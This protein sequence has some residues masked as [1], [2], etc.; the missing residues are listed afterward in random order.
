M[1]TEFRVNSYQSNWQDESHVL[2]LRDGGFLV[3]WSS[4]FNEYD[5]TDLRT[6]YVAAQ[7]YDANAMPVGGE[8]ILRA[9][10]EGSSDAPRATQLKNG[11][12]VVTWSEATND[13]ILTNDTYIAARIFDTSGQA[14][15]DVIYVDTVKSNDAVYPEVVATGSGGFV[16]S[17][18]AE[19]G[20][21]NFDEVYYRSYDADGQALGKDKVLNTR[22]N[23]FDELVHQGRRTEQWQQRH[24]LEFG[25]RDQRRHQ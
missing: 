16:V 12:I 22:S 3:T 21:K 24:H 25:G 23:D 2:A 10:E 14:V 15:S 7:F 4:Y 11:N 20:R 19:T 6:N 1:G 17:F 8:T 13:P 9:I 5:D 18:G